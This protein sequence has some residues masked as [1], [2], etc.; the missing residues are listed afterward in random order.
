MYSTNEPAYHQ[1]SELTV[2]DLTVN[3]LDGKFSITTDDFIIGSYLHG[4][5]VMDLRSTTNGT[6]VRSDTTYGLSAPAC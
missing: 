5:A 2:Q 1:C 4:Q 6:D 3:S